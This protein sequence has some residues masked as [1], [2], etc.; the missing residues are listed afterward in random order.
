[1]DLVACGELELNEFLKLYGHLR[2]GTYDI[3]S[4][5]YAEAPQAYFSEMRLE[6]RDIKNQ[7]RSDASLLDKHRLAIEKELSA[8]GFSIDA[9]ALLEFCRKGI[10]AREFGKFEFTKSVSAIFDLLVRYGEAAGLSRDDIS[11]LDIQEML[12]LGL[13]HPS[14]RLPEWLTARANAFRQ[15]RRF[16]GR[17][18]MPHLI[19]EPEDLCVIELSV[20]R[21]N[22]VTN[23]K[24]SGNIVVV[25]PDTAPSDLTGKIALIESAD[26]GYD[27]IF[28]HQIAGLI[29]RYGG[30]ASHMTIRAS[31]FGLPAAI[32]CGEVLYEKIK[33][34]SFVE[35]DCS[36]KHVRVH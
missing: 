35:L 7:T 26:P 9:S 31:E 16:F 19:M 36:G 20:G 23:E 33:R 11:H 17:L 6:K 8:A 15:E 32:G 3:T 2:P 18:R 24:V 13:D 21:P 34:A 27:W 25:E 10:A 22:F 5:S 14:V 12:A 28:G 4:L 30:A 29:T 1:M